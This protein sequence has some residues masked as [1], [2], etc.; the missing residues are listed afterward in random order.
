MRITI[1]AINSQQN[2]FFTGRI[3]IT[4]EKVLELRKTAK[5]EKE[6]YQALG[7]SMATYYKWLKKLGISSK[8]ENYNSELSKIPQEK[9]EELL[10][11]KTPMDAICKIFKINH[12]IAKGIAI[13]TSSHAIGTAK[14]MELGEVEG[15][16]SSL[17]I[18]VSGI[19]TVL[20]AIIFAH[21]I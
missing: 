19:L 1:N 18:A 5:S 6:V 13:G 3:I 15:A 17:S 4:K 10:K 21:I 8:Q 7:V 14:A 16:M 20:G 2:P 9:F 12:P 11:N